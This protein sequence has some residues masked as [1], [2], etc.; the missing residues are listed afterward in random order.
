VPLPSE[1][2]DG[3]IVDVLLFMEVYAGSCEKRDTF[4]PSGIGC[5]IISEGE[6]EP[7]VNKA[8][9][10]RVEGRDSQAIKGPGNNLAD[11]IIGPLGHNTAKA[12]EEINEPFVAKLVAT[13]V[14]VGDT[15]PVSPESFVMIDCA[16][17]GARAL[18]CQNIAQMGRLKTKGN[19]RRAENEIVD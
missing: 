6:E 1:S 4:L 8:A 18:G 15:R 5:R 2:E 3:G 17:S 7:V 11:A 10:W 16:K 9:Q 12:I 13:Q 14:E 19:D